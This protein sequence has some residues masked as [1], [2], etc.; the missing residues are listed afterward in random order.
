M[1]SLTA[2]ASCFLAIVVT[3]GDFI[4]NSGSSSVETP[5]VVETHS[6]CEQASSMWSTASS[7]RARRSLRR[8]KR[9]FTTVMGREV[10]RSQ[11]SLQSPYFVVSVP[12][13][14][15]FRC[16]LERVL[17]EAVADDPRPAAELGDGRQLQHGHRLL[18]NALRLLVQLLLLF[19]PPTRE[20]FRRSGPLGA[21]FRRVGVLCTSGIEWK[22]TCEAI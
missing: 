18:Q 9:I 19:H 6:T 15:S 21:L 8:E 12:V 5:V 16:P 2:V 4:R 3:L 14:V 11:V 22:L 17:G 20:G 10:V 7:S 1:R 13:V